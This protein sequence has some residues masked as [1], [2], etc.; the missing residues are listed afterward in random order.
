MTSLVSGSK[1]EMR[2][3]G[4]QLEKMMPPSGAT[5]TPSEDT[6]C[7][8]AMSVTVGPA[9][10]GAAAAAM[11]IRPVELCKVTK[12][13]VVV[14]PDVIS[15]EQKKKKTHGDFEKTCGQFREVPK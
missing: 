8:S 9:G 5:Q 10:C 4:L 6:P 3:D 14:T 7:V 2:W 11:V 1:R 12:S 13:V 15:K